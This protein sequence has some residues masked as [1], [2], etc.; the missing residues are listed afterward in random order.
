MSIL[1]MI[2]SAIAAAAV[3]GGIVAVIA[4]NMTKK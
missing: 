1:G 3:I 4:I 2:I